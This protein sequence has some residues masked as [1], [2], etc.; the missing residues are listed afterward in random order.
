[1]NKKIKFVGYLIA[2]GVLVE[3]AH[4]Q[5][6]VPVRDTSVKCLELIHFPEDGSLVHYQGNMIISLD[7]SPYGP[8]GGWVI[9]SD[10]LETLPIEIF[11]YET[12][13]EGTGWSVLV[14]SMSY[15]EKY[16]ETILRRLQKAFLEK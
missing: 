13:H 5:N 9:I 2:L 8:R 1:M 15:D 6:L 10:T 14:D 4:A 12:P 3:S 7:K 16:I 11:F